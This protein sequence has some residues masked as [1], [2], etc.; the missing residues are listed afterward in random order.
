MSNG[1]VIMIVDALDR[2]L[3]L[4]RHPI[5]MWMPEKWGLP[6][7]RVEANETPEDAAIR[8]TREET[9]LEVANLVKAKE[10]ETADIFYTRDYTGTVKLDNEHTE[11]VWVRWESIGEYDV[12]PGVADLF[13]ELIGVY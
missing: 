3:L 8:E 4:K 2:L 1:A 9:T 12:V 7:G 10:V 11:W 6:G 5:S 13:E